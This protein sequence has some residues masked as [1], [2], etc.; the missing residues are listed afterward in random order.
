MDPDKRCPRCGA[1]LAEAGWRPLR[2][3]AGRLGGW[4]HRHE[5]PGG[6]A[7]RRKCV[8]YGGPPLARDDPGA[9]ICAGAA[10]PGV[11]RRAG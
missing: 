9:R 3:V 4:C 5:R 6:H 11:L 8:I 2:A 1:T 10:S 7:G